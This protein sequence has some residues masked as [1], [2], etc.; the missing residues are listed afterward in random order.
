MTQQIQKTETPFQQG[1]K[2]FI[3]RK[4][5]TQVGLSR[6]IYLS[7]TTINQWIH[8]RGADPSITLALLALEGMTLEEMFGKE[9]VDKLVENSR[10]CSNEVVRHV[11]E[12]TSPKPQKPKRTE[13]RK[14]GFISKLASLFSA[15]R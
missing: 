8:G 6:K 12:T 2:K 9:I 3:A 13:I 15:K 5:L 11:A 4:K 10:D 14:T 1:L 7:D